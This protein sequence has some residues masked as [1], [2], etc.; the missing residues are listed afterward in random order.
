M[1]MV[2]GI[3]AEVGANHLKHVEDFY[4]RLM[5]DKGPNARTFGLFDWQSETNKEIIRKAWLASRFGKIFAVPE[6]L[7][8]APWVAAGHPSIYGER[9]FFSSSCFREDTYG[10][11]SNDYFRKV[12]EDQTDRDQLLFGDQTMLIMLSKVETFDNRG[13]AYK[14]N[15][16]SPYITYRPEIVIHTVT[17]EGTGIKSIMNFK[18]ADELGK[19]NPNSLIDRVLSTY[20]IV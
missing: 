18:T 6:I 20:G 12:L 10:L 1:D 13:T 15:E 7:F 2:K 5:N 16:N 9:V 3:L 17:R 14:D 4:P 11:K 19:A 8:V